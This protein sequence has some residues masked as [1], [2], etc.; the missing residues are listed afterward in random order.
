MILFT[1]DSNLRLRITRNSFVD[2][3]RSGRTLRFLLNRRLL[4]RR[5]CACEFVLAN[6]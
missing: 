4:L 5:V 2:L 3:P 1:H 6:M